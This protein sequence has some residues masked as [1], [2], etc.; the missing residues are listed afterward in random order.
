MDQMKL[1]SLTV[2][3]FKVRS[4]ELAELTFELSEIEEAK[5]AAAK[6]FGE[7]IKGLKTWIAH[8]ATIVRNEQEW[9]EAPPEPA[10][11]YEVIGEALKKVVDEVNAGALDSTGVTV[12][13]RR[14]S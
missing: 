3:E 5:S 1:F 13:A 12:T 9:R 6:S 7:Q 11:L 8:V 10:Q 14:E 4:Q 2:K